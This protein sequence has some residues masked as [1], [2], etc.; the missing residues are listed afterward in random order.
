[1]VVVVVN[2]SLD[3][4][5]QVRDVFQNLFI[6]ILSLARPQACPALR[7]VRLRFT[8]LRVGHADS[9][10][11]CSSTVQFS[12]SISVQIWMAVDKHRYYYLKGIPPS[13]LFNFLI[14]EMRPDRAEKEPPHRAITETPIHSLIS[15]DIKKEFYA[16][17]Q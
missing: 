11:K 9:P 2:K 14:K 16:T 17:G 1:M 6:Q 3:S 5:E 15:D 4:K 12:M 7:S 13:H 8:P 10:C